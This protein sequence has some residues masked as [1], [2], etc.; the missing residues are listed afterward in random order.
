MPDRIKPSD[1]VATGAV[2]AP[3]WWQ[4][5]ADAVGVYLPP[6]IAIATFIYM[7]LRVVELCDHLRRH[8]SPTEGGEMAE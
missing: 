5:F 7:A 4:N 1:L 2:S 8:R 6:L 3:L